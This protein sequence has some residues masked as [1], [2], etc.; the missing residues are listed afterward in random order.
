MAIRLAAFLVCSALF[1]QDLRTLILAANQSGNVEFIDPASLITVGRLHFDLGPRSAGLNGVSAS[2]DGASLY[3]EAPAQNEANACCV[4]FAV[5][6]ATLQ[7]KQVASIPGTRSR[8]EF[9]GVPFEMSGDRLLV[10]GDRHWVFGV[11]SFRGPTLDIYDAAAKKI[12]RQL[13][14]QGLTGNWWPA[15]AW[16]GDQFRLYAAN[17]ASEGRLW[18]ISPETTELGAGLPVPP[19]G[20]VTGCSSDAPRSIAASSSDVFLYEEFGFKVDRRN[21]CS[22]KIPG[23][24][25]LMDTS[26]GKLIR[27]M[28]PDL[29]FSALISDPATSQLYG[30]SVEDSYWASPRLVQI[31]PSDGSVLKSRPLDPGF[32]RVA[33]A[34]VRL[35]PSG[36]VTYQTTQSVP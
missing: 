35:T 36:E 12:V 29:H 8:T 32:S 27:Q 6:L 21:G 28:A 30:L 5:D 11:R 7:M 10:S 3:V 9:F 15:G 20:Q 16:A 4:L 31:D 24:A 19:F 13:T 22:S 23:G 25:W 33:M 14:P 18:T 17:A 2:A 26:T 1:G 34:R